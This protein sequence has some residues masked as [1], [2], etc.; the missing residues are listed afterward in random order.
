M[1]RILIVAAALTAML[2]SVTA[3]AS[4]PENLV[5]TREAKLAE[6]RKSIKEVSP[7]EVAE[8]SAKGEAFIMLDIREPEE[9]GM[10]IAVGT[11]KKIPRGLLEWVAG[12]Q[13]NSDDKIVVYCKTG[14]RGAFATHLLNELGYRNAVN[15]KGG[16]VGWLEA[17]YGVQTY[18]GEIK[19]LDYRFSN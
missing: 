6:A 2:L 5:K 15:M 14:A 1:N 17:G 4:A 16:I 10:V 7:A 9:Q 18:I 11:L 12:G 13:L 8:M 3:H 19:P